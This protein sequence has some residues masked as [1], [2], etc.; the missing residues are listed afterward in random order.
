L[1]HFR[2]I[3]DQC[4]DKDRG[5]IVKKEKG[6]G[7]LSRK[8]GAWLSRRWVAKYGDGWHSSEMDG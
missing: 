7:L 4:K 6:A 1:L 3:I 5:I 8:M 2:N